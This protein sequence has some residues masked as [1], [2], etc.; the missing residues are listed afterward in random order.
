MPEDLPRRRWSDGTDGDRLSP[1]DIFDE[2]A[3]LREETSRAR[4]DHTNRVM[5]ALV[6]LERRM[7]KRIEKV[8]A[9]FDRHLAGEQAYRDKLSEKVDGL[10]L[11]MGIAVGVISVVVFLVNLFAPLFQ[12]MLLLPR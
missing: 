6:E 8:E 5:G 12:Q 10:A 3:R 4:H 1:K 7:E 2:I 11:R 9:E